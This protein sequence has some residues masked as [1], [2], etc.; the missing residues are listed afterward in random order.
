LAV[1]QSPF[2]VPCL[3]NASMP[4]CEQVGVYLQLRGSHG[5]MANW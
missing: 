4:Y 5:D 2:S 1:S 3:R